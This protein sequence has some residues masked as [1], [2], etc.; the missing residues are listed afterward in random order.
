MKVRWSWL[1]ALVFYEKRLELATSFCMQHWGMREVTRS[2]RSR[3]GY[4]SCIIFA[5][6]MGWS[7]GEETYDCLHWILRGLEEDSFNYH[8]SMT[9]FD[10]YG[11]T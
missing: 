10:T 6:H 3:G 5:L 8:G 2:L 9:R 7:T 1:S 11:L 4:G